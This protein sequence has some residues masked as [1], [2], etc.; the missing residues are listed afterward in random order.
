MPIPNNIERQHILSAIHQVQREGIPARRS[1]RKFKIYFEGETYPC[2][3]LISWANIYANGQELSSH[4]NVFQT[5]M[6]VSYLRDLGF[7]IT[8][9]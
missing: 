7:T 4:P 1:S 3:L 8:Q 5:N 9:A 2:K 6:A